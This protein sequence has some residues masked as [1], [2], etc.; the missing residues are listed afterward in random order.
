MGSNVGLKPLTKL[1][2]CCLHL[3]S[4]NLMDCSSL[5]RGMKKLY[6]TLEDVQKLKKR[7]PSGNFEGNDSDD[8]F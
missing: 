3:E 7:I 6:P 4:L 2:D 1:L 5:P 8:E